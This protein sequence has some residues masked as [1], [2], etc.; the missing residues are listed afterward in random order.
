MT[1]IAEE[2]QEV[3]CAGKF[4]VQNPKFKQTPKFKPVNPM[5]QKSQGFSFR[6]DSFV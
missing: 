1:G 2:L 5:E 6:L 3:K 4:K